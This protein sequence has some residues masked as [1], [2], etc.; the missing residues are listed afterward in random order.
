MREPLFCIVYTGDGLAV[1]PAHEAT[2]RVQLMKRKHAEEI[3]VK[4]LADGVEDRVLIDFGPE[5]A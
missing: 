1:V 4:L 2:R 3:L 5:V